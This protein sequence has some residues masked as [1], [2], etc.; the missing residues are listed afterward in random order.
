MFLSLRSKYAQNPIEEE[1]A[2]AEKLER[3][4]K[5]IVKLNRGDPP[6]YFPTPEYTLNAFIEAL[7]AGRTTYANA[8]G[9]PELKEAIRLR[10]KRLSRLDVKDEDIIVTQG[11]SEALNFLNSSL[12]NDGEFAIIFKPYYP[13]YLPYLN[14]Y[15]GKEILERYEESK[16]WEINPEMLEKDLKKLKREGKLN[17]VKYILITNPNNPTGTVLRRSVLE[18]IASLANEY[19]L[20]LVSDEIYDEI[21]Y[22]GAAFTSVSEIAKGMPFVI[23]NGASKDFDATGFRLGFAIIPEDDAKSTA[24]K[25]KFADFA[26]VRLSANVPAQYAFAE[27]ISNLAEH[28]K[29]VKKMVKEIELRVNFA[30]DLLRENTYISIIRPNGAFYLFPKLDL[31]SLKFKTDKEFAYKLLIEEN[32]QITRGS[33]FGAP[34]H[35]RIVALPPKDVLEDAISRINEF[36]KKHATS[37]K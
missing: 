18:E 10:Y 23:L 31:E 34:S 28:E 14:I 20:L 21:V 13:I 8:E 4:G 35:I 15:G 3:E 24:L 5:K 25:S 30:V 22:N 1:D 37:K 33:G 36:C 29:A 26:R 32:I 16:G 2:F 7:K 6:V 19:G 27:S 17:K 12:I 11:V 9:I